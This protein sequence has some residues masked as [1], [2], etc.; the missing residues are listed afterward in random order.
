MELQ[1]IEVRAE[2][3]TGMVLPLASQ[4]DVETCRKAYLLRKSGMVWRK[5]E[6]RLDLRASRGL[7]ALR[8]A[9]RWQKW[10]RKNP[11]ALLANPDIHADGVP[12]EIC[13][14]AHVCKQEGETWEAAAEIVG[15][16][17]PSAKAA[18]LASERW[19]KSCRDRGCCERC[20]KKKNHLNT[21][22]FCSTCHAVV[23]VHDN[24]GIPEE[25][26]ESD[27]QKALRG[28]MQFLELGTS[29]SELVKGRVETPTEKVA[30]TA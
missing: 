19:R 13:R 10:V 16:E 18:E 4:V 11:E 3:P 24:R 29:P 5:I 27:D 25:T 17:P 9:R 14:Q 23:H 15:L 21:T 8:A 12:L 2:T 7:E 30:K 6:M 26:V 22:P 1:A 20:G 28:L